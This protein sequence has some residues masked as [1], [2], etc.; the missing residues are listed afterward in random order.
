MRRVVAGYGA[1]LQPLS[2]RRRALSWG[3]APGWYGT[4]LR[5]C[6]LPGPRCGMSAEACPDAAPACDALPCARPL[7]GRAN[8][9][10]RCRGVFGIASPEGATADHRR[11]RRA[12]RRPCVPRGGDRGSP[13]QTL[14]APS[15]SRPRRGRPW[16]VAVGA[17]AVRRAAPNPRSAGRSVRPRQGANWRVRAWSGRAAHAP[18]TTRPCRIRPDR[19]IRSS[20]TVRCGQRANGPHHTSAGAGAPGNRPAASTQGL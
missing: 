18:H 1:G 7:T 8:R 19:L 4:R 12:R 6:N 11:R 14:S 3:V 16:L 9:V 17:G 10:M 2:G 5:R 13:P 20:T 15:A